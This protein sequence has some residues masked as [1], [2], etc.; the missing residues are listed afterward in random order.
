MTSYDL[1]IKQGTVIDGTGAERRVA[2]IAV[3]DGVIAGIGDFSRETAAQVIDAEGSIVAPGVIDTHTHYDASV[4][5]DPYCT[6][7]ALHGTTSVVVGNCGFGFAPCKPEHRERYMQMMETTEQVPLSAQKAAL[8]WEWETFPS[9][10]AF[11][12]AKP[13]GIN[14]ASYLPLNALMIY[15]MGLEAAKSRRATEEEMAEMKRLL[16]EAMDC[17]A[18]GFAFSHL[19]ETNSHVDYDG[20]PMPSDVMSAEDAYELATVLKERDQGVIQ[21]LCDIPAGVDNRHVAEVLAQVS[22]RP[23]IHNVIAA[24]ELMPELHRSR[25]AWVSECR[26]KGLD[27]YSMSLCFRAWNQFNADDYNAWNST[28]LFREFSTQPD[29]AAKLAK[30][31]DDE[32]RQ[33][34]RDGYVAEEMFAAGGPL[35]SYI[36][37]DACDVADYVPFEG[38]PMAE[39]T[40]AMGKHITDAFMD[41]NLASELEADFVTVQATSN[42]PDKI[43]EILDNP[44]IM[45]GT[46]DGG[47]HVKFYS[48]GQFSTDLIMWLVKEEGRYTL[49]QMHHKLSA[50]PAEAFGFNDRGTLEVGKAA[51]LLIYDYDKFGLQRNRYEKAHDLPDGSWRRE[52]K[53]QG[54]EW[55]VVNGQPIYHNNERLD[56]LPGGMVSPRAA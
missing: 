48:G 11:M 53:P 18:I 39:V 44:A 22:G 33:R 13:L 25:V 4:H 17:G 20:T 47:A 32:Y 16:N 51:D 8:S 1:I 50:Q 56:N 52:C 40:A 24:F 14:M 54:M 42:D 10:M 26:E 7:S 23:V 38:K 31:A 34:L 43:V 15:V 29:K 45:A 35:E 49:E 36:L 28:P 55:V 41:L 19:E 9:W 30:L 12:R 46:S 3:L 5:W 6:N 27:L 21:C 37:V 2:D